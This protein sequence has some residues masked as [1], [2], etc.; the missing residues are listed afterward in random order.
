MISQKVQLEESRQHVY[1]IELL[2]IS[3][4]AKTVEK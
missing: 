3:K 1:L 2:K 4:N